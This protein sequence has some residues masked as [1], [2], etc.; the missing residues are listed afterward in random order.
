M[1]ISSGKKK[2]LTIF[3]L[4]TAL[5]IIYWPDDGGSGQSERQAGAGFANKPA[6]EREGTYGAYFTR[7]QG[8]ARPDRVVLIEGEQ[9]TEAEGMAVEIFDSYADSSGPSIVTQESGMVTWEVE[10]PEDGLYNIAVNYYPIAGKSSSIERELRINGNVPFEGA[11]RLVFPRMWAN[12]REETVRDNRDNDLRPAQVEKPMWQEL[13]LRDRDGY[14]LE[15]YAFQLKAGLNRISLVSLREPMVI[16]YI[17]LYQVE[18]TP[19]Y[20]EVSATYENRGNKQ[21]QVLRIQ[22]EDASMKSSPML[23]PLMDR[24]SPATEPYHVSKLRINT[25][26]G[27]NW[28][29]PGDWISWTIDV[30]ETGLYQLAIKTNKISFGDGFHTQTAY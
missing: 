22:G 28:R 27:I 8:E 30:P 13:P 3:V 23:Y 15:P 10:V 4:V 26:G 12:E 25:I 29:L 17:K 11:E 14:Y 19:S 16:D 21:A 18:E 2:I 5:L 24:S 1:H 6:V 9:Y 7:H 20:A